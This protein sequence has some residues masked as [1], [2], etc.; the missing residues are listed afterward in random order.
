M[1]RLRRNA[2]HAPIFTPALPG[3]GAA[4]PLRIS[5][6]R[7]V[8]PVTG[9]STRR[10]LRLVF[11]VLLA[12]SLATGA[13]LLTRP[14]ALPIRSVRIE[15]EFA[16]VT[17]DE[18]QQAIA[19]AASGDL[20][21]VDMGA[22]QRA[23]L[24]LP[25]VHHVTV[26]RVWPD[27]L[28]VSVTEQRA[29][30]IWNTR[31]L[32]NEDGVAFYPDQASLPALAELTGPPG[33]ERLLLGHLRAVQKMLAP[34]KLEVTRLTLDERRALSAAL[35]NGTELILGRDEIYARVT[36]FTRM[37]PLLAGRG[38]MQRAD[39]RYSNG[40]AVRWATE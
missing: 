34:L 37:Y 31:G 30:A 10:A 6:A 2:E 17:R 18:L 13:W 3:R 35:D 27:G 12:A 25:W 38:A 32:L 7:P 15:G 14:G 39:L 29:A 36:R 24:A 9:A 1:Q 23:A 20:F 33:S 16:R 5:A 26:R 4:P 19:E 21:S 11:S 28:R 40:L 8:T 22:I